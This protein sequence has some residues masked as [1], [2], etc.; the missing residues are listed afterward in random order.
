MID[1]DPGRAFGTGGHATTRLVIALGEEIA[2]GPSSAS[3]IWVRLG[4]LS[5]AAVRLWPAARG[6]AVDIDPESVATTDENLALNKVTSVRRGWGASTRWP[7]PSD[8][9]LANIEAG[10]LASWRPSFRRAWP[11]RAVILS[12]ILVDQADVVLRAFVAAGFALE[13]RR[14]EDEWAALRLRA[15]WRAAAVRPGRAA[16]R[17]AADADRART[18]PHRAG[19]A[20]AAGRRAD[21]VRRRRRRGGGAHRADR[22]RDR[23]GAG[24]RR[25]G[26]PPAVALTLLCGVPRGPRMDFLVQKTSELGVARDRSGRHRALGG[27]PRRRAG[28]RALGKDRPRGGAAVRSGRPADRR[29][30]V[31]LARRWRAPTCRRGGWRCSRVKARP[32]C[33]GTGRAG[34]GATALLVGPEGASTGRAG[35]GARGGI[36]GVGLGERILRVETAAIVAV[37]LVA[38]AYGI[39][40]EA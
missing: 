24:A 3:W 37:A 40:I 5:I 2:D 7:A 26:W 6:L 1:L 27:P 17:S 10:V 36:R 38:A 16:G 12:G 32:A 11:R 25:T 31:A 29:S 35:G 13:A 20:R 19:A 8:L 22:A 23:A 21:A 33:G 30:A 14:D 9:V 34:A 18:S 4:I 15:S 28:K 39:W